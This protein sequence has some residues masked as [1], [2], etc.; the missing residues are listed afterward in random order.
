[1]SG[2]SFAGGAHFLRD[3]VKL[4]LTKDVKSMR[5]FENLL[6]P[7]STELPE[8]MCGTEMQLD[9]TK[10]RGDAEVRIFRCA[11]CRHEFQLMVW[12]PIVQQDHTEA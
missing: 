5:T 10:P 9:K 4:V 2:Y 8:C 11:S 7:G 1:M 6:V 12:R 3:V